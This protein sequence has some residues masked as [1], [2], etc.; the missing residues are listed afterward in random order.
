MNS[1]TKTTYRPACVGQ[2]RQPRCGI[3][4][5]HAICGEICDPVEEQLPSMEQG[6]IDAE[7][8]PKIWR[9]R[10]VTRAILDNTHLLT[11]LQKEIVRLYY[12]ENMLQR[13]IGERLGTTQQAVNDHLRRIREKIGKDLKITRYV[14]GL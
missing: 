8:L 5:F 1:N 6:R 12:R 14:E 10:I 11:E 7:D 2:N 9:G 3:C 4:A 13:E